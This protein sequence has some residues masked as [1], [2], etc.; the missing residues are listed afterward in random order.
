M[1][2]VEIENGHGLPSSIIPSGGDVEVNTTYIRGEMQ[3]F[4]VAA[5]TPTT[6][7]DVKLIDKNGRINRHYQE[8]VG[9]LRDDAP[10][11]M[12]GKFTIAIENSTRN[13]AFQVLMRIQEI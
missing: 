3:F 9:V 13:E 10:F 11:G 5:L 1:V 7:F 4:Y 6:Q 12:M 8:E 2:Y